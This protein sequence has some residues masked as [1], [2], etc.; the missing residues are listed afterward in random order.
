MYN[1]ICWQCRRT[2]D[3]IEQLKEDGF[4]SIIRERTGL[5]PDAYFS[6]TKIKWILDNVEGAREM[7]ESGELLFGTVDTWLILE[8]DQ[9]KGFCNGLHQ[10]FPYHAF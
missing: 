7:A 1:A 2:A 5:V 3:I 4:D 10:C 8:P 6:G 9:G